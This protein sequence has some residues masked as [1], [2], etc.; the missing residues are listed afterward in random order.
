MARTAWSGFIRAAKEI[1]DQGSFGGFKGLTPFAEL[2]EFF[3][4]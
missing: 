3:R 2:N 4:S 1:A